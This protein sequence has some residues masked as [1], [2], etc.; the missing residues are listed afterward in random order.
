M[1]V[2][3]FCSVGTTEVR[4]YIGLAIYILSL[5]V[6]K[7]NKI[8]SVKIKDR[9]FENEILIQVIDYDGY[10]YYRTDNVV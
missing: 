3:R 2:L 4:L 9:G 8:V 1:T 7:E 5:M 6:R 10:G